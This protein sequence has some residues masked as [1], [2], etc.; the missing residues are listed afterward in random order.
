[1]KIRTSFV[2][3]SS[4]SSFIITNRTDEDKTMMDFVKETL[5][6]LDDYKKEYGDYSHYSES[7]YY[8]F[9]F[10][11]EELK[12]D[13]EILKAKESREFVF[14]DEQN[15]LINVCYDYMLRDGGRTNSF[16]WY[17]YES[18]R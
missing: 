15:D 12:L 14:G 4:S 8:D 7:T 1:M 18:L 9:L 16:S 2:S 3:N 10:C 11:A 13:N 5:Y 17:F 6:L